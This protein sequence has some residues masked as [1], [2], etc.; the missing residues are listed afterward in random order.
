MPS[1]VAGMWSTLS[2]RIRWLVLWATLPAVLLVVYQARAHRTD[3]IAVAEERA[4]Q[5][6]Q[7][8]AGT[9]QRL[10][11]NTRQFLQ[12]LAAM[13][14]VHDPSASQCGR[15]LAEV[16]SLNATYVN[17]GVPRADGEL[18]CNARPLKAP[19][20]VANRPY[21]QQTIS[22][23]DFAVGSFQVDRAA[24][25]A[26]VNFAYPVI[27]PG[28]QEVVAAAV[29]VVSLEW[30]SR[31]L[32]DLGLPD[33]AVAR[34]SD[35]EGRVLARYPP[36]ASELGAP[37]ADGEFRALVLQTPQG[38]RQ[39][40][41]ADGT[42]ELVVFQPLIEAGG[43]P[44]ATMS[45]TVPLDNL[46]AEANRRMWTEMAFLLGGLVLSFAV[47]QVGVRRGVMRPLRRLMHATDE[48]A[49]GR[50]VSRVPATG[51]QE[52]TELGRRFDRMALTRQKAEAELRQSEENLAITL[53]SIGDGVIATDA[54]GRITRMNV[55]AERLTGWPLAQAMGQPLPEVFHIVN[56]GTRE[57]QI[58]P[59]QLVMDRGQVVALSNHTTLLARH[60]A[61]YHIADSAAP[62]R[63][64]QGQIV[65]VVLVFSDVSESYRVRRK[66]E[67]N[68]ARF[69][70]LTALSS[71]WYWEQDAQFR[72]THVEGRADDRVV[73]EAALHMG[74]TRWELAAPGMSDALW[75]E[76]RALLERHQ[77]F[78]DFEF[79][80]RDQQGCSYWVSIS[81]T[82]VF[83]DDG[84]FCGYRGVGKDI[85]ARKR[86]ENEL[87]IAAIAFES[88]EGMIVTDADTLILRT[89]RAFS[90]ITGYSADEVV[91]R[92]T[93]LL[94]S[95]HHD[96]AFFD[97]MWASLASTGEWKGELWNRC[98]S[99]EVNLHFMA[100][101]A[102]TDQHRVL[103]HYVATLSDITQRAAAAREIEHLAFYDPLTH[104]PNR[105]LMMD[106]LQQA[107]ATSA[108]AGL[109]GAL[110]CLDLDHFKTLNDT[111]GHDMG[112]VLLQQVAQRLT[113]CVREGD[114]VARLGGDEFL[115]LLEDLG[116]L[117]TDA[118]EQ[119]QA[120]G[121]KILAALNQPYQLASHHVHSTTSVGAVLFSGQ[122]QTVEDVV[123]HAD[124]AMYAA[125]T[126]GRNGIRFF[127]PRMQAAVTAR[128]ALENDL[129]TALEQGQFT[130]H[131]QVQVG[132]GK[133]VVGAEVLIRWN[134]PA[135][136]MVPPFEFIPL[137][138][139]TGLILPIGL[140]VLQTACTQLRRWQDDPATAH[141]QLAV[142]VSARQ[143][144]QADF[145]EQVVAVLRQTGARPD[146]L[147]LELT[148]SLALDNVDDTIA[149][150][151]ALRALGLRFSMDDFGTGQ[152][153]LS[154]LT[155]LPLDQLKIDQSFVRN[156]GIQHTDALIVQTIIGMAQ[157]LGI[158]VIAEGVETEAQRAFLERHGC[159]LWQ[160]YLFSRPVP[161][162]VLEHR[163]HSG[164]GWQVST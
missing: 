50:Y 101:T 161:I 35:P 82:P 94:A 21:F 29:A 48:L 18:L 74:K 97:A 66:L 96:K 63:N 85:S 115:V 57:P 142:N 25:V 113:A 4:L 163:L 37:F 88:Q 151:N 148:E 99:G 134:H 87:R 132:C 36:D 150:M 40:T 44:V 3:A 106:R 75:E 144:R 145:M 157:S 14:Q 147:K 30:W 81:G 102:V 6:L 121:E 5:T 8:V 103:T 62:I 118:A 112:D 135:R 123:K 95:G 84:V 127:D 100:I 61:E 110:L 83:D 32:T 53:L 28:T 12:Q 164:L 77:E 13:P 10:I 72:L 138:E 46:Y 11:Q 9:Q 15:Y 114:T 109:Q 42:P 68:E 19:V 86:D 27:P 22:G 23:R 158:D 43:K 67:D 160:G 141:L 89:N 104:L 76:H 2:A 140:W 154:Y 116:A 155:R 58:D 70:T 143:F 33:G 107:F 51:L 136:G 90:R 34:V 129:R 1:W 122:G 139:E 79:E 49:E 38:Q 26:S 41:R 108:R 39:R 69:R 131:Y 128:A 52:L 153:S 17:I 65:G 78:R 119:A 64:A 93:S 91:G 71:D 125:K 59:V 133:H 73:Q 47:A 152:S 120:V 130:L 80:R 105:R 45:L 60:G 126:A 55:V 137:A 16:L 149:K 117:A 24:Q 162:E 98:K 20:N 56:A 7:S 31:R 146:R 111:L 124:L 159:T 156:I 92:S 54:Q